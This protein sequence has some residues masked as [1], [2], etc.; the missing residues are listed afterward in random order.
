MRDKFHFLAEFTFQKSSTSLREYCLGSKS[1]FITSS[2]TVVYSTRQATKDR[3]VMLSGDTQ[4]DMQ[5][6]SN[7]HLR[8]SCMQLY[9]WNT[10]WARICD[11]AASKKYSNAWLLDDRSVELLKAEKECFSTVNFLNR[12]CIIN[13]GLI[14]EKVR[15]INEFYN[16][17]KVLFC[18]ERRLLPGRP[19]LHFVIV[20]ALRKRS[21]RRYSS[22]GA[23]LLTV[24]LA[25]SRSLRAHCVRH[26][27][28]S[29]SRRTFRASFLR[30]AARDQPLNPRAQQADA[31]SVITDNQT[32]PPAW[33][34]FVVLFCA[35]SFERP[36]S[37]DVARNKN[38]SWPADLWYLFSFI[39]FASL[40]P[41]IFCCFRGS[42][43]R[44]PWHFSDDE[45]IRGNSA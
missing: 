14:Y 21:F 34:S 30:H 41:R 26:F 12:M 13:F 36:A 25:V 17:C 18:A 15:Q 28:S 3:G 43:S 7:E 16:S 10:S 4:N 39:H 2:R 5:G 29:V 31:R 38:N 44:L 45:Q 8:F 33:A 20:T 23:S 22:S 1:N 9:Q 19:P 24:E 40:A 37:Y 32:V 35:F 6:K 11:I 27:E 42:N